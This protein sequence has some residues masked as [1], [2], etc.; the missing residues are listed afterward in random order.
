[1]TSISSALDGMNQAISSLNTTASQIA[2]TGHSP[3]RTPPASKPAASDGD[4]GGDTVN[5]SSEM[6]AL[7]NSRD[8]FEANAKTVGVSDQMTKSTLDMV[9]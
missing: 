8:S 3:S 6:V 4:S 7:L 9:G 1:M 5:L 2:R